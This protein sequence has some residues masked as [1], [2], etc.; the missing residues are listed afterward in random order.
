MGIWPWVNSLGNAVA[1]N[2]LFRA[3]FTRR[4][5]SSKG[6]MTDLHYLNEHEQ[7]CIFMGKDQRPQILILKS[8]FRLLA[9]FMKLCTLGFP[10]II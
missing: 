7:V 4:L 1:L 5:P 8:K 6:T 2:P 3:H 10:R 9:M